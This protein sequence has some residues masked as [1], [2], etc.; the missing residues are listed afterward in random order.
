VLNPE[1]TEDDLRNF[2]LDWDSQN[3]SRAIQSLLGHK[4]KKLRIRLMDL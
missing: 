1:I 2:A 3:G 4:S